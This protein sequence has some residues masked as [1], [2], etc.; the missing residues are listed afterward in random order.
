MT[1]AT[2][3]SLLAAL[4]L[5]A[6]PA[7]A[8]F[9][10]KGPPQELDKRPTCSS[11]YRKTLELEIAALEKLRGAGPKLVGQVCTLIEGGSNIVGGELSDSARRRIKGLLGFDVDLRLIKTQCRQNQGDLDRT[12]MTELGFL[13][14]EQQ[15]CSSDTI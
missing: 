7:R 2:R 14:S 3:L 12:L 15:R 10:F 1:F 13:K 6:G 11:D 4:V 8:D 5:L 9:L